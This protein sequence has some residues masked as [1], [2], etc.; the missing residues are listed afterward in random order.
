MTTWVLEHPWGPMEWEL[1]PCGPRH[2]TPKTPKLLLWSFLVPLEILGDWFFS[3]AWDGFRWSF[4][5]IAGT[6]AP[7]TRW[8]LGD[9][10]YF[11]LRTALK[12]RPK[13]P[14][15]ANRQLSPTANRHQPPTATNR[16]PSTTADRHQ[17]PITKSQL[18][19]IAANCGQ[20]RTAN[21]H[22]A[23]STSRQPPIANRHQPCL[24]I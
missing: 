1:G 8:S 12:D 11:L 14:P 19:P 20:L 13:G 4:G 5:D 21:R 18:P 24:E 3:E 17:L 10:I 15:T 23:I 2:G 22:P 6:T 7:T 9:Q 16:Q